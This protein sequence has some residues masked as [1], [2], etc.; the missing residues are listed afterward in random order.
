MAPI[1]IEEQRAEKNNLKFATVIRT[2]IKP[3][4][5]RLPQ[6]KVETTHDNSYRY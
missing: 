6:A 1:V 3:K 5:Y 2:P 4:T